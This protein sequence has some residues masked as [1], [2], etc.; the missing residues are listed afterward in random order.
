MSRR[1]LLLA[2]VT[3]VTA[4]LFSAPDAQADPV[5]CTCV[6]G[7]ACY[8]F[9]NCPVKAPRDPCSCPRCRI[10]PGTCPKKL[11]EGWDA[12]CAS[13]NRMECFLRRH[14]A[15]WKL[16]CSEQLSGKCKCKNEHPEFCPRCGHDGKPWNAEGL[17]IVR[18][19]VEVERRLLGRRTKLI[20]ITSPHF[21]LVT[22]VPRLKL[23]GVPRSAGRHEFAHLFIQRA[24][25]AY[26]DFVRVFGD[27]VHLPRPCGIYLLEDE[28]VKHMVANKYFGLPKPE[29]YYGGE[30][31]R[32]GGGYPYNGCAISL[33]K[34]RDDLTLHA[35]MRHLI[36]HLLISCWVKVSG[37]NKY[38]PRWVFAGAA[39]WLSR[40]PKMLEDIASFCAGEGS[41][42][43]HSG[44]GWVKAV[45]LAA[46]DR[47]SRS[48]QS[49]FDITSIGGLDLE[50]HIRSWSLFE[51][52]LAED[53]E[54]FVTFLALVREGAEERTALQKTMGITPE[55][56]EQRWRD[57]VLGKRHSMAPTAEE[58]DV[59]NPADPGAILRASLRT[60]SHL[61][62]LASKM[63]A[64]ETVEDPLTARTIVQ[65]MR[66]P[67]DVV[68]ECAVHLLARKPSPE[69]RAWLRTEGLEQT[70]GPIRAQVVRVLGMLKDWDARVAIEKLV[71]DEHWLVRANVARALGQLGSRFS[72]PTLSTL[73]GERVIPVQLSALDGLAG[74]GAS[75]ALCWSEVADLLGS[76][77]W[78]VQ[79]AAAAC[80]GALGEMKAV[81]PLIARMEIEAGRVRKDILEALKVLTKDDLGENP[82]HWR[83][84]WEKLRVEKG[85]KPRP[86]PRA[87]ATGDG[88]YGEVPT[89]Y[90]LKLYSARIA[91]VIDSS[92]SMAFTIK[93]DPKWLEKH[94]RAYPA[95]ATKYALARHEVNASLQTLDRR[96]QV[97]VFFFRTTASRWKKDMV[98][99]SPRRREALV[100]RVNSEAPP[101]GG[102]GPGYRTNYVDV[103]RLILD[104]G[105]D[106]PLRPKLANTADTIYFLTD[107][108]PSAGDIT[109]TDELRSWFRER[110]RFAR[111]R[112]HVI[113]FG[114][115]DV[116]DEF[117]RRLAEEN[118]GVLVQVPQAK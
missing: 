88:R 5:K 81:E 34:H 19:Q 51:Y 3:V 86:Q 28:S 24:E 73:L 84:W 13:N 48:L 115:T 89:Y 69:V 10:A 56:Y 23:D 68:R 57:R 41:S 106:E 53:R 103:L 59:S 105:K 43:S 66:S 1:R 6:E 72:R 39:Q 45:E 4:M 2:F 46:A 26:Q 79:S 64:I 98:F 101:R 17:A 82:R 55:E 78:Q 25:M 97:N 76:R 74:L 49:M 70:R 31:T 33:Q 116:N 7:N 91:Y 29:I 61:E 50:T 104:V 108:K 16:A 11:P 94:G 90:G 22:D 75:G 35:R 80:L 102:G 60:E 38:L 110:N 42:V 85:G 21:Y 77:H 111:M 36:G 14:A 37:K 40:R 87:G 63:R 93:I 8:H 117:L 32:I 65:L 100:G 109:R 67:S 9:L 27:R 95:H 18:R 30:I 113:A 15:S 92:A 83:E 118:Y 62:T 12:T 44:K 112:F 47:K 99:A 71:M 52:A 96:A 54:R 107:G 114:R 20:V 58:L